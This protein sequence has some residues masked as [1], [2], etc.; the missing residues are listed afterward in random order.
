LK[1][2]INILRKCESNNAYKSEIF[3]TEQLISIQLHWRRTLVLQLNTERW[4]K[5]KMYKCATQ[6]MLIN[7]PKDRTKKIRKP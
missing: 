1:F 7:E 2:D 6:Q 4:A 5:N 3:C